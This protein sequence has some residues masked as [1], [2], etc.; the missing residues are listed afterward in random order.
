LR[1]IPSL[2]IKQT[3][4]IAGLDLNGSVHTSF[5]EMKVRVDQDFE[6]RPTVFD[7]QQHVRI[8]SIQHPLQEAAICVVLKQEL[9]RPS[10]L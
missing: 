7:S 9:A 5:A 6:L 3:V 1:Q 4:K 2:K 8:G 10:R